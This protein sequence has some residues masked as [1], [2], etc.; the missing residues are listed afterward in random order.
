MNNN[1][2]NKKVC[3]TNAY[4]WTKQQTSENQAER[5]KHKRTFYSIVDGYRSLRIPN[6]LIREELNKTANFL[7]VF[8]LERYYKHI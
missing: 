8:I 2:I 5:E 7:V 3:L 1:E 6:I 4:I